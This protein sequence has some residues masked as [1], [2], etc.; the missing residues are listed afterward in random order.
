MARALACAEVLAAGADPG[1]LADYLVDR[2]VAA[3]PPARARG[4]VGDALEAVVGAE[5]LKE[6]AEGAFRYSGHSGP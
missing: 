4:T 1:I 3:R 6:S 2:R 5:A